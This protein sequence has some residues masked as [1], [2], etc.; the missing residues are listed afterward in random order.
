[1]LSFNKKNT[2]YSF[3]VYWLMIVFHG[4]TLIFLIKFLKFLKLDFIPDQI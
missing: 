2:K 1:M 3:I 4:F